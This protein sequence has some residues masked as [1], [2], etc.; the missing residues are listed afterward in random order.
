MSSEAFTV[1]YNKG[2]D[3][4]SRRE[5]SRHELMQKLDKRYPESSPIIEEALDKLEVNRILDDERFAEMYVNSRARKGFGP[6]KIEM[7]L[8][9]KRVDSTITSNALEVY[10]TWLE[11]AQKELKK[12]FKDQ[13]PTDYQSKMKQKQFLFTRGFSGSIIDKVL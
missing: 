10:E 1:I 13:K 8:N 5:H 3:L 11:N 2:L 4:V 9:A 7:E 12:K 6:K